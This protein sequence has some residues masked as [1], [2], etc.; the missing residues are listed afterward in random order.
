LDLWLMGP[1]WGLN[2]LGFD[3]TTQDSEVLGL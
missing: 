2:S 3:C 1:A